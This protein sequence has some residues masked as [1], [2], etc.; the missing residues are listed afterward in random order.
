MDSRRKYTRIS[1]VITGI[2]LV[3]IAALW[4]MG[5]ITWGHGAADVTRYGE[6]DESEEYVI[7]DGIKFPCGQYELVMVTEN[8]VFL[9]TDK[10]HRIQVLHQEKTLDDFWNTKDERMKTSRS[11]GFE[12][13]ADPEKYSSGDRDYIKYAL[14]QQ[15]DDETTD[16]SEYMQIFLTPDYKGDRLFICINYNKDMD[17][18][19]EAERKAMYD[20]SSAWIQELMDAGESTDEPDDDTGK[21]IYSATALKNKENYAD[22]DTLTS[23]CRTVQYGLPYGYLRKDDSDPDSAYYESDSGKTYLYIAIKDYSALLTDDESLKEYV[24]S[25]AK[26]DHAMPQD[27]GSKEMDGRVFYYYSYFTQNWCDDGSVIVEYNF[28]AYC[29]IGEGQIYT[30]SAHSYTN[31]DVMDTDTYLECM[32]LDIKL[33]I[34]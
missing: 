3:V 32:K 9:D 30:I 31:S 33:N 1:C 19:T 11:A 7:Y 20:K 8:G 23:A 26:N 17:D 27:C 16:Y 15:S 2:V 4:F 25:Y 14:R 10:G 13:D 22:S 29:D 18:M 28:K 21:I 12:I 34:K 6:A 5:M 24:D